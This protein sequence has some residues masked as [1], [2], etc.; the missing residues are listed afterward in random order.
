M[1]T[2]NRQG[3]E[4]A[5]GGNNGSSRFLDLDPNNIEDISILKGLAASTLYGQQGRNG[6]VLITTKGGASGNVNKKMDITV[7]QSVFANKIASIGDYQNDFGNG[8]NAVFGW[9]FSNWGPG[10]F[11]NGLAGWGS[12]ATIDDQGNLTHPYSNWTNPALRA[13]FPEFQTGEPGNVYPWQSYKPTERFYRTGT[14]NTTSINVR[15]RSD[16]GK[17]SFNVNAGF[18]NDEGFIPGNEL[19]RINFGIGGSTKLA[20]NFTFNSTMNL[21]RTDFVSPPMSA[22]TVMVQLTS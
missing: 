17:S 12:D 13:G 11:E 10:F 15:G 8:F 16:D 7:T 9:F 19:Q 6:V 5:D 20:N 14:V 1:K 2:P 4:F 22:S 18:M 3:A 21:S